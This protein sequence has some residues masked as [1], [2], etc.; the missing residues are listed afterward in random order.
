MR[1]I[2]FIPQ[3][4]N[5]I[6]LGDDETEM[7]K[8]T[9]VFPNDEV[10][11]NTIAIH[12]PQ[13]IICNTSDTCIMPVVPMC[14]R[15]AVSLRR[16]YKYNHLSDELIHVKSVGDGTEY[17]GKIVEKIEDYCLPDSISPGVSEAVNE[18]Q[19]YTD[20]ELDTG[21]YESGYLNVNIMEYV[22]FPFL[23]GKYEIWLSFYGL[24]SNHTIVEIVQRSTVK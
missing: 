18:A 4:F 7:V 23:P 19:Q 11:I 22:D 9:L 12:T 14:V 17:S 15:Y 8:T 2:E 16:A 24:E 1:D 10:K 6:K 5:D 3:E 13:Q 21:Q 20:T